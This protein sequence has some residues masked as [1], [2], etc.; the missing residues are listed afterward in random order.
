[1]VRELPN[2]VLDRSELA[3]LTVE[4]ES[5]FMSTKKRASS[6]SAK[7]GRNSKGGTST[8]A[9][10]SPKSPPS[11]KQGSGLKG[12]TIPVA[13]AG[14]SPKPGKVENAIRR[15]IKGISATVGSMAPPGSPERVAAG[16]AAVAGGALIAGATLGAGPAALAGAAGYLAYKGLSG[17][18][19]KKGKTGSATH[20]RSNTRKPKS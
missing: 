18:E 13:K 14:S 6:T 4:K 7:L 15:N 5:E 11:L 12:H 17:P 20:K 9:R 19:T 16:V 10:T 3:A 1:L 8:K 2:I